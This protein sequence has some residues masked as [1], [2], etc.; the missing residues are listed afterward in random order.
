VTIAL[1]MNHSASL[2][3]PQLTAR[4]DLG[5]SLASGALY[6]RGADAQAFAE[7]FAALAQR[8]LVA[9]LDGDGATFRQALCFP[10]SG[11]ALDGSITPA[12]GASPYLLVEMISGH[13]ACLRLADCMPGRFSPAAL[14]RRIATSL[15]RLA[16]GVAAWP[17]IER[18]IAL[19]TRRRIV[20]VD[21]VVHADADQFWRECHAQGEAR[22]AEA[23]FRGLPPIASRHR[24]QAVAA[25]VDIQSNHYRA[26]INGFIDGLDGELIKS[27]RACGLSPSVARYNSYRGGEPSAARNRIQAA[28]A[29][30]LLGY[31]LGEENHR[32]ARLR[33]LV[34]SGTP[35][36]P[37]LADSV[38]VPE[39]T[40]RWLRGKTA[41]E[42]SDAW[43]GRIP[44]LLQSLSLLPPEKRPSSHDE[45]TAYTDF[46]LVLRHV[47]SA[48]RRAFWLRDLARLG[49]IAARQKFAAIGAVPSDLLEI[50]DLLREITGAVGGE[51]LPLL[52]L[53]TGHRH[54]D[55]P[56]W[57]R[58]SAAIETLF[59]ETGLLKQLRASLRWHELQLLPPVEEEA[60]ATATDDGEDTAARL[61][62]WPAPL[63]GPVKLGA[64][65]AHFLTTTSELRDEGL[66][67]EHCVGSYA[68]RCLFDGTTIVSLRSKD[69]RSL[70]TAE[71]R[72]VGSGERLGFELV[73]HKAQRNGC[74][75]TLAAQAM[76]QLLGRLAEDDLQPRLRQM[77]EQ[78][79]TR[80]A[81]DGNRQRWQA[82]TPLA[83][84]RLHCLKTALKLHVAY[85]RFFEAGRK[86]LDA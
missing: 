24:Q 10:A 52:P 53:L 60:Q 18:S 63:T 67:M 9:H 80:R 72:L 3:G 16:Q 42:I 20:L 28:A 5:R 82:E 71:L 78:L 21:F 26:A 69:G 40:V 31:L 8:P 30:P 46:A 48:Q 36:W 19:M 54:D 43:L 68:S 57:Q 33:R 79:M 2:P 15:E 61:K 7:Q 17:G 22:L 35:L 12:I 73:Q 11:S 37:A 74:P 4:L 59:L 56:E 84:N 83:P 50:V 86:A 70:S 34:D 44:E 58:V 65:S 32:A 77:R 39:E 29:V 23:L 64:L 25:L 55:D 41:D 66:R 47:S 75:S 45:W 6:L 62:H 51:L 85:E 38:G 14:L 1:K 27:I 81:L 76:A 13:L 49:W